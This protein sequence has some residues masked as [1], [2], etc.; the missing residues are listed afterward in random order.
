MQQMLEQARLNLT[1]LSPQEVNDAVATGVVI[2]DTRTP[3][4]RERF[5]CIPGAVHAPRTLLEFMVEPTWGYQHE[6]IDGFDQLLVVVCNGGFSSS[7][8]AANLQALGFCRATDMVGGMLAWVAAGL[9]IES[10]PYQRLD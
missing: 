1:R 10:P 9:P 7:L 8:S 4:D 5:G 6:A 3:T 2:L